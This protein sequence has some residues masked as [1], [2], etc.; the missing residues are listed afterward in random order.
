MTEFLF[1]MAR[2][3]HAVSLLTGVWQCGYRFTEVPVTGVRDQRAE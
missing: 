3:N 1:E 2:D